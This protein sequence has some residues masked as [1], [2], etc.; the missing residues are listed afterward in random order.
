MRF[1]PPLLPR[2]GGAARDR[3]AVWWAPLPAVHLG[4]LR[5][6]CL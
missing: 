4:R 5:V 2:A 1:P 3:R 6:R